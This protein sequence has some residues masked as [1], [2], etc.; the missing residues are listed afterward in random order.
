F[1]GT[2][3][4]THLTVTGRP[5]PGAPQPPSAQTVLMHPAGG[6][7]LA[8]A[9]NQLYLL[10]VPPVGGEA[11]TVS[12][13]GGG[14]PVER[15]TDIGADYF[16]WADGG[17]TLFWAIGSTLFRRPLDTISFGDEEPEDE[18]EAEPGDDAP[19]GFLGQPADSVAAAD[20]ARLADAAS[21][22]K[23]PLDWEEDVARTEIVLEFP[24]AIPRGTV[25]LSGGRVVTMNAANEVIERGDV[26]VTDNRIVAVGPTGSIDVPGGARVIDARG[27]TVVPGFID[28]HAHWEFRTHDVLEPH[29]WSLLANLAWG[30]TAGLDVQTSTSDYFAYQDLVETGRIVGQRAFMTGP[31]I[32]RRSDFKSYDEVE[33]YLRRYAEHYRTENIK[34]Y[35]VGNRQ[36][37]QWVVMA[38]DTLGLMPTTEGARDM[39][40]DITHAIDGFHGNE[41]TLPVTPL[42]AD[43]VQLFAHTR[44][45]YTPTLL[46]LYGGPSGH[47]YWFQREQPLL[48]PKLRRWY[49]PNWLAEL[50]RRRRMWVMEDEHNFPEAAEAAAKIQRAG[51]L[52]GVGGHGEVQGLGYH[53]EMWSLAMGGMTP[54]EVLRAATIDGARIIGFDADLGSIE[55]GKLA[56]LVILDANPLEDI[57]NTDSVWR[58]MKNGVLYEADTLTEVWPHEGTALPP[59]WWWGGEAMVGG[60]R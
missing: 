13:T 10:P 9:G 51:G 6:W 24:R 48:N 34:S 54:E 45:A 35:V 49:P 38:S 43:V 56:D 4:R 39:K 14:V 52:V 17:E 59:L 21:E 46:V 50:T 55:H 30:V 26:V 5:V 29:N 12:V 44:T 28:T 16:G 3:R 22:E 19:P 32:F 40:L 36:Q 60:A 1:D 18:E 42:F 57:R 37:R 31:G 20:S 27:R 2:D 58:V 25:V 11:P 23:G 8:A 47:E 33:A 41:H 15:I 53:W 7:A